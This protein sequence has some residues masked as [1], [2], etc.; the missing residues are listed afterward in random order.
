MNVLAQREVGEVMNG[1]DELTGLR[2][3]MVAA[4]G[5]HHDLNGTYGMIRTS[6]ETSDIV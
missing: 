4:M 5:N 3:F 1:Y 6:A 2:F